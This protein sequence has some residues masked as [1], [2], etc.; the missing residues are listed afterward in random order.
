MN[1]N[2]LLL[3]CAAT[4]SYGMEDDGL[5]LVVGS[6]RAK[7]NI[8]FPYQQ[9]WQE[10]HAD[11]RHIYTYNGKATTMDKRCCWTNEKHIKH[12]AHDART[13][14]FAKNSIS[15]AYLERLP[16]SSIVA[17]GNYIGECIQNIGKAMKPD[18]IM[19]IEWHP[20]T[21]FNLKHLH[22]KEAKIKKTPFTI[23][24]DINVALKA[25]DRMCYN[26]I[27]ADNDSPC[28]TCVME[29]RTILEQYLSFYE[30]ENVGKVDVLKERLYQE[31]IFIKELRTHDA[32]LLSHGP[33]AGLKE[34]AEA[35]NDCLLI[36]KEDP[37]LIGTVQTI[38]EDNINF[39]GTLYNLNYFLMD[40]LFNV[41]MCDADIESNS[42]YVKEF[43]HNNGFKDVTIER[44]TSP[45][46]GRKNVWI[47]KGVK[48]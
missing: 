20:Y 25:V 17:K 22:N 47:V 18:A 34:F 32:V 5:Y 29:L 24:Y 30:K 33:S 6:T 43:M 36:K 15:A 11:L 45:H 41:I 38:T 28:K 8:G 14:N 26:N 23:R 13:Y 1:K 44:T 42:P 37:S 27:F 12:I 31:I 19:E 4:L 35:G 46:N 39:T 48:S 21:I 7:R 10:D 2:V 40:S 16:T 9:L 3:L